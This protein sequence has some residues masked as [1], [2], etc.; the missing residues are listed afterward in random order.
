MDWIVRKARKADRDQ[1]LQLYLRV[2]GVPGHL[3]RRE[4]EVDEEFVDELL[5]ESMDRGLALV[6]HH[7]ATPRIV[8][9]I[10]AVRGAPESLRHVM[11]QLTI[12]VDPAFQ[13]RG[14]GTVLF[15]SFLAE[16]EAGF[17]EVLRVELRARASNLHALRLYESLGFER[18]GLFSRRI[19]GADGELEDG[20]PMAWIN[21][22]W[23]VPSANSSTLPA[24]FS[25]TT[26]GG[27]SPSAYNDSS[28]AIG[29]ERK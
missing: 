4:S 13:R 27:F 2:A 24:Q 14:G 28:Q 12:L 1:I 3:A 16:V 8:G 7:F 20:I 25:E 9:L 21:P 23:R 17:P 10:H 22:R 18:E 26:G 11:A 5:R 6:L 29:G 15:S 19:L